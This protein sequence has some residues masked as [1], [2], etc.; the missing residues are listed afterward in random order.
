V[1]RGPKRKR[2][3]GLEKEVERAGP[4][5]GGKL[6]YRL[7]TATGA[8]ILPDEALTGE[9]GALLAAWVMTGSITEA[10]RQIGMNPSYARRIMSQHP[11]VSVVKRKLEEHLKATGDKALVESVATWEELVPKAKGVMLSLLDSE[12]EKVRLWAA[13]DIV[14]RAEGKPTARVD[15]TVT[16]QNSPSLPEADVQLAVSL[17]SQLGWPLAQALEWIRQHPEEAAGWRLARAVEVQPVEVPALLPGSG[18]AV[19]AHDHQGGA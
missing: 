11:V 1:R 19:Q 17:V 16:H 18:D 15:H 6:L 3:K 5:R 14:N 8:E 7:R 2:D 10:A 12:D 13:Q 9:Q 4:V